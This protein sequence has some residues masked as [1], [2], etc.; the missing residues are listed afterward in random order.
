MKNRPTL[1]RMYVIMTQPQ[2]TSWTYSY[3]LPTLL[4]GSLYVNNSLSVHQTGYLCKAV[5]SK[6]ICWIGFMVGDQEEETFRQTGTEEK[7]P[8]D[9]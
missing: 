7:K 9:D 6:H 1:G 2:T 3:E 8:F 5:I 4:S